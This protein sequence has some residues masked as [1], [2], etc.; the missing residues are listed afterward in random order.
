MLKMKKYIIISLLILIV[1]VALN[2]F[3]SSERD[4]SIESNYSSAEIVQTESINDFRCSVCYSNYNEKNLCPICDYRTCP[5]CG[6]DKYNNRDL[7]CEKCGYSLEDICPKCGVN[8]SI[9]G[10]P[11]ILNE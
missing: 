1:G 8:Y 7:Y 6:E 3:Q 4:N 2:F 5:S 10:C 9:C 11:R